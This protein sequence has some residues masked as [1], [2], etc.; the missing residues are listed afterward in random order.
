MSAPQP[1]WWWYKYKWWQQQQC[2]SHCGGRLLFCSHASGISQ[3]G[4]D[5]A[6]DQQRN[7]PLLRARQSVGIYWKLSRF[8]TFHCY[9]G[10]W[11]QKNDKIMRSHHLWPQ[12]A[13][14]NSSKSWTEMRYMFSCVRTISAFI[15]PSQPTYLDIE[16]PR[17]GESTYG[18]YG[19]P[20]VYVL[21]T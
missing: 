14:H 5:P 20:K 3:T 19:F 4:W 18:L 6:E 16:E 13:W 9:L 7:Q 21:E 10:L 17:L 15:F 12:E 8:L 11:E 1:W 2:D